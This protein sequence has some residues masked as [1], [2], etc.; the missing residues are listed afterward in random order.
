MA[1]VGS[2]VSDSLAAPVGNDGDGTQLSRLFFSKI[3]TP[4]GVS[5]II[6]VVG[7]RYRTIEGETRHGMR[8]TRLSNYDTMVSP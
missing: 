1:V 8:G 4:I 3:H 7:E 5:I 2:L 6:G